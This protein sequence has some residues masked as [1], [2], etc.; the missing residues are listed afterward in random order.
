MRVSSRTREFQTDSQQP[1]PKEHNKPQPSN[2]PTRALSMAWINITLRRCGHFGSRKQVWKRALAAPACSSGMFFGRSRRH[3]AVTHRCDNANNR[4]G[5]MRRAPTRQANKHTVWEREVDK[6]RGRKKGNSSTRVTQDIWSSRSSPALTCLL[7]PPSRT[8]CS[9]KT[10]AYS[11]NCSLS[12]TN[13]ISTCTHP[14]ASHSSHFGLSDCQ[15]AAID[16]RAVIDQWN[17]AA[18]PFSSGSFLWSVHS[19][20]AFYGVYRGRPIIFSE[21]NAYLSPP[22]LHRRAFR[23]HL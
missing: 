6:I 20:R 23:L 19:G 21:R 16:T 3:I 14:F 15:I 17:R 11:Q 4:L 10:L 9:R 22:P 2:D 18:R 12:P 7:P 8:S 5:L 1:S 13:M